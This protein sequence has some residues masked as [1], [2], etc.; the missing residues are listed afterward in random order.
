MQ[1]SAIPF[2]EEDFAEYLFHPFEALQGM[3]LD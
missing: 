1:E 2:P 3:A